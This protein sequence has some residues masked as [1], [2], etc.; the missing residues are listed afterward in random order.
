M[1]SSVATPECPTTPPSDIIPSKTPKKPPKH[2]KEIKLLTNMVTALA[3]KLKKRDLQVEKLQK[4]ADQFNEV[5]LKLES[6]EER[7]VDM[8]IENKSLS[9]RVRGLQSTIKM[10]DVEESNRWNTQD[11]TESGKT[12]VNTT[13]TTTTT[14]EEL[15]QVRLQRDS[16]MA[17]AGEMAMSLAE[18]RSETDELRDQLA[19][20]TE[21]LQ[22]QKDGA[23][24][25]SS[26]DDDESLSGTPRR[27]LQG[28]LKEISKMWGSG[29]SLSFGGSSRSLFKGAL[30]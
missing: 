22:I 14:T 28:N 24:D 10:Q 7:M 26:D 8:A 25:I 11:K 12:T 3:Q 1:P 29:R 18:S 20:V 5:S 2:D 23:L 19:A 17:K 15:R 16:A 27:T 9:R 6:S 4:K 21:M 13:T 30:E